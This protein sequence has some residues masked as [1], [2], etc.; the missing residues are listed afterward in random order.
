MLRGD[1]YQ[2]QLGQ[3]EQQQQGQ[4]QQQQQRDIGGLEKLKQQKQQE[5]NKSKNSMCGSLRDPQVGCLLLLECLLLLLPQ[6]STCVA[7]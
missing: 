5:K 3:Q 1:C 6:G 7:A 2:Q 4:Q